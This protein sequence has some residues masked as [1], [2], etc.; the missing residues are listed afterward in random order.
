MSLL[1][2]LIIGYYFDSIKIGIFY[3]L[4]VDLMVIEA[5]FDTV[6][7]SAITIGRQARPAHMCTVC[8]GAG[9]PKFLGLILKF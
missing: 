5:E 3:E 1:K 8:A 9:P 4:L 7:F 6:R 2:W